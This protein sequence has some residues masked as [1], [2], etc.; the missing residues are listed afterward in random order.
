MVSRLFRSRRLVFQAFKAA[1]DSI[2]A[3]GDGLGKA[4]WLLAPR[5]VLTCGK[6]ARKGGI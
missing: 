6:N 3:S 5:P 1:H 2:E 4:F